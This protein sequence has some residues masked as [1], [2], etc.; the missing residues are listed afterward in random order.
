MRYNFACALTSPEGVEEVHQEPVLAEFQL[1]CSSCKADGLDPLR[2]DPRF[3]AM[4]AT[5]EARLA[6]AGDSSVPPAPH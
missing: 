5:A 6:T 1:A 2:D 3:Q 4:V